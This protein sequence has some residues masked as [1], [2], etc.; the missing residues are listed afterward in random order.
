MPHQSEMCSYTYGCIRYMWLCYVS[1]PSSKVSEKKMRDSFNE[2][3]ENIVWFCFSVSIL[4]LL[5]QEHLSFIAKIIDKTWLFLIFWEMESNKPRSKHFQWCVWW[6]SLAK[7]SGLQF[8]SQPYNF[9][10]SL[11]VDWFQPFKRTQHSTGVIFLAIQN[12][13]RSE[14]FK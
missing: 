14:R 6:K 12:L 1:Q 9:A 13:P 11:N 2:I 5:L 3:C 4:T 10:F 8:L 7:F